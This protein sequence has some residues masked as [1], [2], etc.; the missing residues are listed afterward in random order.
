[1]HG[2][3]SLQIWQG[4]IRRAIA[5][6]RRAQQREQRLVLVY[7]KELA[8]AQRPTPWRKTKGKQPDFRE[9]RLGH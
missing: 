9:K 7:R 4:E 1:M 8:I 3:T 6:V 2:H 5:A